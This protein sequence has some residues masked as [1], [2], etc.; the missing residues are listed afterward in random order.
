MSNINLKDKEL[1]YDLIRADAEQR[2]LKPMWHF[3]EPID[4]KFETEDEVKVKFIG[5]SDFNSWVNEAYQISS[6]TWT[7]KVIDKTQIEMWESIKKE[8]YPTVPFECFTFTIAIENV[9][10]A[11]LAQVQRHR[12]LYLHQLGY[13]EL[14]TRNTDLR[15]CIIRIPK[16]IVNSPT[17]QRY[18]DTMLNVMQFYADMIDGKAYNYDSSFDSGVPFEEARM[19]VPLGLCTYVT[20]TGNVRVWMDYFK[21]RSQTISQ[22][23]HA[24]L[25]DKIIDVFKA[26]YPMMWELIKERCGFK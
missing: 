16:S 20:I 9:S 14:S 25:V 7:D 6:A 11:I 18:K 5:G 13:G 19:V 10:R 12:G 21:A 15:K 23:E 4:V 17:E 1:P 22:Y 3:R 8:K 24:V 2:G 26:K